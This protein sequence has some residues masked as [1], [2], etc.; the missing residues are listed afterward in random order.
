[1]LYKNKAT[2]KIFKNRFT[3]ENT[4]SFRLIGRHN[5]IYS[6][7]FKNI[8]FQTEYIVLILKKS[9]VLIFGP[10]EVMKKI[11]IVQSYLDNNFKEKAIKINIK[12]DNNIS[13]LS[14]SFIESNLLVEQIFRRSWITNF[15]T[16][17]LVN[18]IKK[19]FLKKFKYLQEN[20][21]TFET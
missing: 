5:R 4:Y 9:G 6:V 7:D 2:I 13:Q 20:V 15:T 14:C 12:D 16:L 19:M 17:K 18:E 3:Y 1:M 8:I 21:T 11:N 10:Y